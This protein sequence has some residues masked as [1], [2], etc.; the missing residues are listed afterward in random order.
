MPRGHQKIARWSWPAEKEK[1]QAAGYELVAGVDEA[2]CGA[3]AGP[4]VAGAAL[5]PLNARLR[6]LR[7]S[8][9]LSPAQ[10]EEIYARIIERGFVCSIGMAYVQEINRLNIFHA[11]RLAMCRAVERLV[12]RPQFLLVDGHLPPHFGIPCQA[13]VHGDDL[14]PLISAASVIA[15]VYR[16]RLMEHLALLYPHYGFE[17]HKGYATRRHRRA[18]QEYGPSPVHRR[19][20]APVR[21]AEQLALKLG[22]NQAGPP[23]LPEE[24]D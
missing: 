2:G 7:D 8:K 22:G 10:R 3:L 13:V 5:V 24:T 12:P 16:D 17:V 21:A 11:A 15:K 18:L 9:Q 1:L 14:C 4:V 19:G 20:F 23:A 6:G